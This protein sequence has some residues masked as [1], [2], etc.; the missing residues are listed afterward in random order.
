MLG[1]VI[2]VVEDQALI[3]YALAAELEDASFKVLEAKFGSEALE[4]LNSGARVAVLFTDVRMPGHVDGWELAERARRRRVDLPVICAT[5][6]SSIRGRQV[7]GSV[8][9]M[10]PMTIEMVL[11]ALARFGL[12]TR[13]KSAP[14]QPNR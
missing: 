3:P 13:R 5:G 4:I 7:P 14:M 8:L 1:D 2:L 9:I 11:E 10:K 12:P 6:Y